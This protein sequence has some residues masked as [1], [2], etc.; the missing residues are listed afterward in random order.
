MD[1]LL[2]GNIICFVA[3]IMMVFTG[4][5]IKKEKIIVSQMIQMF[6]LTLG[7]IVLGSIPGAISDL[8]GALRNYLYYKGKFNLI[9]KVIII[10]LS[11]IM[12]L[13][14][15]NL[16]LMGI[17][18]I[19]SIVLYTWFIDAKNIRC[20]KWIIIITSVMWAIH[21]FYISSYVMGV[22]DLLTV[23]TNFISLFR[24]KK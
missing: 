24:L 8:L 9:I 16:G 17:L 15:N 14:F 22:M 5:I 21:D 4:I 23:V 7:N 3:A 6:L 2:L 13:M 11:V 18:P 1:N 20:F 12:T 19:M 10:I